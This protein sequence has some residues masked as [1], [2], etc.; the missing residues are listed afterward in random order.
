MAIRD[1]A[2]L[3]KVVP[4]PEGV[5]IAGGGDAA[6]GRDLPQVPSV[7]DENAVEAAVQLK[8]STGCRVT[9]FCVGPADAEPMLRRTLAMGADEAVLIE[10][11]LHWD[12]LAAARAL[13]AALSARPRFDLVLCGREAADTGAGLVGPYVAQML[14]IGFLT[15]VTSLRSDGDTLVV[16]RVCDGG[17][18][19]FRCQP[20]LL[21]TIT[22]EANRPRMPSVIKVLQAKKATIARAGVDPDTVPA[23]PG[24]RSARLGERTTPTT[25]GRCSFL[26]GANASDQALALVDALRREGAL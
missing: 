2:V 11:D 5:F 4:D 19:V 14:G 1:V 15:L 24:P 25:T 6:L 13:A 22:G 18:D 26:E 20:P 10:R 21:L 16:E 8:E 23:A 7:F 9:V 3:F 17:H 12:S